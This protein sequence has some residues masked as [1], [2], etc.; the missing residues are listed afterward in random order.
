MFK[1]VPGT[2]PEY[3]FRG[4]TKCYSEMSGLNIVQRLQYVHDHADVTLRSGKNSGKSLKR[5]QEFITRANKS[6]DDELD[7][8]FANVYFNFHETSRS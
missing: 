2:V 1:S 4:G 7:R 8:F 5:A 3:E 6:T